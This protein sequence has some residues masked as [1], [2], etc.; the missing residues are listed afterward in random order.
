MST[1]RVCCEHIPKA[2]A[3]SGLRARRSRLPHNHRQTLPPC[4]KMAGSE[5]LETMVMG[6]AMPPASASTLPIRMSPSP[7]LSRS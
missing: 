1:V 7:P 5:S 4:V 2:I 6:A 3:I